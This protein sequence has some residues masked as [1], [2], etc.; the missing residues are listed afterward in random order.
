MSGITNDFS[1][2]KSRHAIFEKC[3]RSYF[4][5]Y[6]QSW[7]G[8]ETTAPPETRE[9]Y[10]LKNLENRFSWSGKVSH[11]TMSTALELIRQRKPM[12]PAK[13]IDDAHKTMQL[14]FQNSK[15][16][17]YWVKR[18]RKEF[19]G[20]IEHELDENLPV[21]EWRGIWNATEAGLTWW[22]KSKWVELAK[23]LKP[24]QWLATDTKDFSNLATEHRGIRFYGLPDFAYLDDAGA[25][26][27]DWKTGKPRSGF[28]AGVVGYAIFLQSKFGLDASTMTGKLA[29]L[30]DGS[31]REMKITADVLDSFNEAYDHSVERMKS[32]LLGKG[33]KNRPLPAE[34][35]PLT[36]DLEACSRCAYRRTC[37]RG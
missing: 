22:F 2:S 5:R 33:E 36:K 10:V 14:D 31:E 26:V 20:L 37:K 3:E 18:S 13:L 24:E 19:G 1:W 6:Y 35:F 9:A 25:T 23:S 32:K 11:A 7:E 15:A 12:D 21:D 28:D 8:W 30:R 16:K 29:F 4:L 27:V 34:A 17:R